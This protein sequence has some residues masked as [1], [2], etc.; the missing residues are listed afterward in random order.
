MAMTICIPSWALTPLLLARPSAP[1]ASLSTPSPP[2]SLT[3]LL[4][5]PLP[6]V[7]MMI[8]LLRS[9]HVWPKKPTRIAALAHAVEAEREA[10]LTQQDHHAADAH[11]RDAL[12]PVIRERE[13]TKP[14]VDHDTNCH[15]S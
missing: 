7:P 12:D 3:S 1:K 9:E 5:A 10:A 15:H 2:W 4:L 14:D 13:T 8:A 6:S 11:I